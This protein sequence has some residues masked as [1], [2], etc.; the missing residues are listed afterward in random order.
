MATVKVGY[1]N[2][3]IKLGE[4]FKEAFFKD[5][6]LSLGRNLTS[7]E[8]EGFTIDIDR[9][10]LDYSTRDLKGML[11][12]AEDWLGF[13][14]ANIQYKGNSQDIV[15]NFHKWLVDNYFTEEEIEAYLEKEE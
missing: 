3:E 4:C 7:E 11:K 14:E 1:Y 12:P 5:F 8:K 10:S 6:E 9:K 13:A 15:D 2:L